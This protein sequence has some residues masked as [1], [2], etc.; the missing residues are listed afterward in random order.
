MFF[1]SAQNPSPEQL[2][3]LTAINIALAILLVLLPIKLLLPGSITW[4]L[5][6]GLPLL[7]VIFGYLAIYN[8]MRRYIYRKVNLIYKTI[9]NMKSPTAKAV[10]N[11]D[12]SKHMIDEVEQ[13]VVTWAQNWTE[14][15]STLKSME[16]YRREFM[17]NVSHELKT[18]IFN[19]Q[20]YLHTLL[21]GGMDDPDINYK[22]LTRAAS[23]AERM[24]NIVA[25]LGYISK[26][27]AQKLQLHL[28]D[29]NIVQLVKDVLDD[30]ELT[31]TD[32]NLKLALKNP[33]QKPLYVSADVQSI[34]QVLVNLISNSIKYGREG[35]QTLVNFYDLDTNV[36]IE[37]SDDGKGI[38]QE[39]LPRLFERFYRVDKGRA[40]AEGG[41]G[42]GLAIVKHILEAHGQTITARSRLNVGSTFSFTLKKAER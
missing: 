12:M 34:R 31:A 16:E 4:G 29:F 15:I 35:G 1:F 33:T 23:N 7:C 14:E 39:H 26:F 42:L 19:I 30:S 10:V 37:I 36:L 21:D 40:R 3:R 8:S 5:V 38:A 6:A 17:G 13:E 11:V 9:Y 28:V 18:P 27:E 2:V 20:G 32:S 25:D 41:T 22:Y 24:A